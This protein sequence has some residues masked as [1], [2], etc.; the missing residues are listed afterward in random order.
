MRKVYAWLGCI[1]LAVQ[2]GQLHAQQPT[3]PYRMM[4]PDRRARCLEVLELEKLNIDSQS[5]SVTYYPEQMILYI[6]YMAVINWVQGFLA[7]AQADNAYHYPQVATWLFSY[8]RANP[9]KSLP[10][11]AHQ[12]SNALSQH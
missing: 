3:A 12:L 2:G 10:D 5:G 6:D 4:L 8:C 7:G 1:V 9:A 11:V